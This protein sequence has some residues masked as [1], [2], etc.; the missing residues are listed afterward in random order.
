MNHKQHTSKMLTAL[1]HV[2]CL[3]TITTGSGYAQNIAINADGSAADKN[4]MLDIRSTTK[5]L[6]IPRMTSEARMKIP[7]TQGL[8]VY[9]ITTNSFWY[10][11]GRRW[12]NLT[13]L[14]GENLLAPVMDSAWVLTGN[15]NTIDG[16]HF[17]G[18][19]NNVSF[20]V[21]VN[22][23]RSGRIDPSLNNTL[24]GYRAGTAIGTSIFGGNNNTGIGAS[25]LFSTS[26]GG[27]NTAV[28]FEAMFTNSFGFSNVAVG[29]RAMRANTFGGG[30]TAVGVQALQDN[31]TGVTNTAVGQ[32]A[33]LRNTGG[34]NNT[35]M[36]AAAM[37]NGALA[38]NNSAFGAQAF[39]NNSNGSNNTALGF[40]SLNQSS[41]G[42][43]NTAVGSSALRSNTGGHNNIGV[44]VEAL[45]GNTTGVE[46]T[47][48]GFR[49]LYINSTGIENTGVGSY[50][51][52]ANTTGNNNT[53][54]GH[55]SLT[56]HTIGTRNTAV[57]THSM[58]Q[59]TTASHNTAIGADAMRQNTTGGSNTAL[60]SAA[61]YST[62]TGTS[63]TANGGASLFNNT[64]GGANTAV[65]TSALVQ[66]TS[67]SFNT[68]IGFL[69]GQGNVTGSNNTYIGN[70]TG[71]PDGL[72]N[73]TAIGFGA[74]VNASNKI[75]IGS[76]LVTVIEGQVPFTFPSDGRYKFGV[77]EDVKGLD[78]I[79]QLRPVTYHFDTK[80]FD[81]H[82][83]EGSVDNNNDASHNEA[84]NIRRT[85]FIAQEVEQAAIKSGY[86]FS[87]VVKPKSASEHYSLSYDAFVV[88]LVKAM[89]EQ[90]QII[91][92]QNKKIADMQ[93][94]L[95][96]IK[97]A[98][99]L[100]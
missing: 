75:R 37:M 23:L 19:T 1:L 97:K 52:F 13:P 57:G 34:N 59:T 53:A 27:D 67:G 69:A 60:G 81:A 47:A 92:Q 54:V 82:L 79:L 61:L 35:A 80:R 16:T 83:H 86:D 95:N 6:L 46:N 88:P 5:G 2:I 25:A 85:G 71:S 48:L 50:A 70:Q 78:F 40:F 38:F 20:N 41:T 28:G 14:A 31:T 3:I 30:N 33:M 93:R 68:A 45:F 36:G 89:Q 84:T 4:A 73:S 32:N 12:E 91:E 55:S 66:N 44:G 29:S 10:N 99:K 43:A 87:G 21:R 8:M 76:T 63:N 74:V 42:Q 51:M 62:T 94:E 56:N 90:Q 49:T 39:Q 77:Q 22:N 11:T 100:Q 9:D 26:L 58:N 64:S 98:L 72:T 7:N 18:T 24:W 17:L 65:G 96:E 15:A